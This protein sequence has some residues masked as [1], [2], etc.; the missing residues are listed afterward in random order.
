MFSFPISQCSNLYSATSPRLHPCTTSHQSPSAHKIECDYRV[1]G[2]ACEE[3]EAHAF[4]S[5]LLKGPTFHAPLTIDSLPTYRCRRLLRTRHAHRWLARI[6]SAQRVS[7]SWWASLDICS[8]S[9]QNSPWIDVTLSYPGQFLPLLLSR[10]QSDI[11]IFE[12]KCSVPVMVCPPSIF[13]LNLHMFKR[14]LGRPPPFAP[15]AT[16]VS[17]PHQESYSRLA[18]RGRD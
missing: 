17:A 5:I 8:T 18:R 7:D 9:T 16:A 15:S 14:D 12:Q 2:L 3:R 10:L 6:G 4:G 13:R 1:P 11:K